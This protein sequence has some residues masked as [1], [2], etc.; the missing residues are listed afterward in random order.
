MLYRSPNDVGFFSLTSRSFSYFK[1]NDV[2]LCSVEEQQRMMEVGANSFYKCPIC[3]SKT[4]MNAS[5]LQGHLVRKHPEHVTY[6]GD[7]VAHTKIVTQKLGNSLLSKRLFVIL[8]ERQFVFSCLRGN[9]FF[10]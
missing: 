7:A 8:S 6:I 3:P 2:I 9:S 10:L 4:F 5:Y 1:P